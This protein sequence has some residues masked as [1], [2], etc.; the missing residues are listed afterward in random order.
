M[1][2]IE[3]IASELRDEANVDFLSLPFIIGSAQEEMHLRGDDEIRLTVLEIV[4]RLMQSN[5]YPGDYDY[6]THILFWPG[7]PGEILSRIEDEWTSFGTMPDE[8]RPICWFALRPA[9]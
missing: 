6:A 2:L 8:E 7:T 5:I 3:K 4:K 1:S 9:Q